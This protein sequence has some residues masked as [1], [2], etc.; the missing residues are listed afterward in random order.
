[1]HTLLTVLA[2]IVGYKALG[3]VWQ[4]LPRLDVDGWLCRWRPWLMTRENALLAQNAA[5]A[6]IAK[7]WQDQR[8][9]D[10]AK[11]LATLPDSPQSVEETAE[12]VAVFERVSADSRFRDL[13]PTQ[14]TAAAQRIARLGPE[15]LGAVPL[16]KRPSVSQ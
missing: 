6:E 12:V 1:M 13:P 4:A 10:V 8:D 9:R 2:A 3:W 16:A 15:F 7:V 14:R 11:A 5:C